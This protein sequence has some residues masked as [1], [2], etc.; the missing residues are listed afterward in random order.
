MADKGWETRICCCRR[1]QRPRGT[2]CQNVPGD[3][4]HLLDF[5]AEVR[6]FWK[7]CI[8]SSAHTDHPDCS[9]SGIR[10][11][12]SCLD[13]L[14]HCGWSSN[15]FLFRQS[16]WLL[17]LTVAPQTLDFSKVPPLFTRNPG[18][19]AKPSSHSLCAVWHRSC[20][21]LGGLRGMCTEHPK[22]VWPPGPYLLPMPSSLPSVFIEAITTS[23]LDQSLCF[24][25]YP[26]PPHPTP[27][28]PAHSNWSNRF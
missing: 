13:T 20:S 18:A 28:Q 2:K 9:L 23:H 5:L 15:S 3:A 16:N 4:R 14:R 24:Y 12:R 19:L 6:A 21:S 10:G 25:P 22:L 27:P 8:L 7:T 26:L 1:I 11:A 17:C